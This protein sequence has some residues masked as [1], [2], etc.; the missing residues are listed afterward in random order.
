MC[1]VYFPAKDVPFHRATI[2]SKYSPANV[3]EGG[4]YWSLMT[5]TSASEHKPIERDRLVEDTC[6]ALRRTG[7]L[8]EADEIVSKWS[9]C[10]EYGYPIPTIGR[11]GA[12]EHIQPELMRHGIYS[13]GRFGGWKYEVSNQDQGLMQGVEV[14]DRLLLGSHELTYWFPHVANDPTYYRAGE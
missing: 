5:E 11:D 8:T 1:W 9:F 7:M 14:V 3:P 6:R 10:S 4:P 2:F 13:R 12:L